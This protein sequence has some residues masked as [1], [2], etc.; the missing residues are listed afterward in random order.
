MHY[1]FH[2]FAITDVCETGRQLA[3]LIMFTFLNKGVTRLFF[4]NPESDFACRK[5]DIGVLGL[6]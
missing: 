4:S 3:A 5:L 1:I 2:D 6:V